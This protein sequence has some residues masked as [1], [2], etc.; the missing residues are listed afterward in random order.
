MSGLPI[1]ITFTHLYLEVKGIHIVKINLHFD[2][3]IIQKFMC[4]SY[5]YFLEEFQG[6]GYRLET[7]SGLKARQRLTSPI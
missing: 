2:H 1:R 4:V 6:R 5:G 7:G 3:K